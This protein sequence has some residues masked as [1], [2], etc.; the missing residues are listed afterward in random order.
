MAIIAV[1]AFGKMPFVMRGIE[2]E[3]VGID[4]ALK[5]L[6]GRTR[7]LPP[8]VRFLPLAARDHQ[9][10]VQQ[11]VRTGDREDDPTAAGREREHVAVLGVNEPGR[12]GQPLRAHLRR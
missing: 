6:S 9:L 8:L 12:P 10:A 4:D 1:A 11:V 2:L 5:L 7:G 3:A